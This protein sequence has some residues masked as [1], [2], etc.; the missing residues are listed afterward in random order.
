MTEAFDTA[1]L[2]VNARHVPGLLHGLFLALL[3]L[4][5]VAG[6]QVLG[7]LMAVGLM[8]LPAVAARCWARTVTR[9]A[10][11]GG[12]QRYFLRVARTQSLLG[13]QPARGA[14]HRAYRQRAVLYFH[15]IWH[16]QQ[17]GWQPACAFLTQGETMKRTGFV[18][19]LALGMMSQTVMAK[20]LNV[21]T[22]FSI[23]GDMTREVG[24]DHVNVT[25]LVGP[26]GDP[27]TFEPSP[28]DSAALSKADVV[29]VNGLGLEGWLDRLVKASGFK[30]QL[31]VASRGVQTHTLEEEAKPS[32]TRTPGTA[33]RT[34]R[35][36]RKIFST[37]W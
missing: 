33:R 20:T 14:I 36:T 18:V 32:L 16:A 3:V 19:A 9:T 17:A 7:T 22:S 10:I 26:D 28:K 15:F 13:R 25:T 27:H 21:V 34:G 23:L 35:C 6:F 4:N 29:V 1:W 30:G 12:Y 5:L 2:Q 11:D 8:M 37:G 24:G 31:V